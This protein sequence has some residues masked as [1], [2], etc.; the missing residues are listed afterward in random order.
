MGTFLTLQ[1]LFSIAIALAGVC[2]FVLAPYLPS[3]FPSWF[4]RFIGFFTV[5][6]SLIALWEL[7]GSWLGS[8]CVGG[9]ALIVMLTAHVLQTRKLAH[10]GED[11]ES[12]S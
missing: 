10:D 8:A 7:T 2:I 4:V 5:C 12:E 11:S 9:F 1:N 3:F 6:S